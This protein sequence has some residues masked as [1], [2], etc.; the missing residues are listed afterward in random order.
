MGAAEVGGAVGCRLVAG[1]V[2]G[3]AAVR[4]GRR[5]RPTSARGGNCCTG[6]PVIAASMKAFQ[7]PE[8]TPPPVASPRTPGIS[9]VRGVP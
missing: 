6:C 1:A 9:I 3:R 5:A 7:T 4:R 2:G 8:A